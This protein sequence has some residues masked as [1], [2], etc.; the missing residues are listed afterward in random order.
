MYVTVVWL[1]IHQLSINSHVANDYYDHLL[2]NISYIL[3]IGILQHTSV[4]KSQTFVT[5]VLVSKKQTARLS[6]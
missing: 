2:T 3:A 5:V 1:C 4:N 6:S